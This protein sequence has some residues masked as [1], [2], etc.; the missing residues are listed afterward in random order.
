MAIV[1]LPFILIFILVLTAVIYVPIAFWLKAKQKFNF[2]NSVSI[3]ALVVFI[4]SYSFH[5]WSI[6]GYTYLNS[7]GYQ[8]VSDGV[9]TVPGY[10]STIGI[11]FFYSVVGAIFSAFIYFVLRKIS[12]K[13]DE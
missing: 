7:G 13:E 8:K 4:F 3:T 11:A 9:V 2:A 12:A 10:I 1:Y 6:S 5:I